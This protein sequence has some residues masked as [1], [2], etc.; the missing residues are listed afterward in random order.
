[1]TTHTI[2][3]PDASSSSRLAA[4]RAV[5]HGLFALSLVLALAT[6]SNHWLFGP[7]TWLPV[8]S[9]PPF[10]P[11]RVD[12][13]A[14]QP[15]TIGVLTFVP[16]ALAV[17]WA[18]LRILEARWGALHR[19]WRWGWPGFTWPLLGLTVVALVGV[20]S[21]APDSPSWVT[22]GQAFS[23]AALALIWGCYLFLVNEQPRLTWALAVVIAVQ[24]SIGV[25]QFVLQRDIGLVALGER[26]LD[27]TVEGT[28]VF[29]VEGR[30]W[31]RAYGLTG[32]PNMLGSLL[33]LTMLLLVPAVR[34]AEGVASLALT[35]TLTMGVLGMLATVSRAAWLAG[36]IGAG[37]IGLAAWRESRSDVPST[38]ARHHASRLAVWLPLVSMGAAGL[39]FLTIYGGQMSTRFFRLDSAVEVQSLS[40]RRRDAAMALHLIAQHP[41]QGVGL[42]NYLTAARRIDPDA[43]LAHSAPLLAWA[44]L[45]APAGVLW[46]VLMLAP[47]AAVARAA[48]R[49]DT[50][51]TSDLAPWLALCV[52][53][54]WQPMPWISVGWTPALL[55]ALLMGV[56]ANAVTRHA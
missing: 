2:R 52:L 54:F 25:G 56:W 22:S 18:W 21:L 36:G 7:L 14:G 43:D 35:A 33:A 51:L 41:W 29:V 31:L 47:F 48:M 20:V 11:T 34:R 40:E 8:L 38:R 27:R 16:V 50:R 45:G 32:H 46:M 49:G 3:M 53:Q 30:P 1:M 5:M 23:I 17:T 6:H 15:M 19:P 13:T 55:L 28:S 37:F 42:G 44:E 10:M 9:L 4:L 24:G 12:G 39:I 26:V